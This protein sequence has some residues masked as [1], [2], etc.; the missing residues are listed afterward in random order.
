[1]SYPA[2]AYYPGPMESH[3][4]LGTENTLF[5]MDSV[6]ATLAGSTPPKDANAGGSSIHPVVDQSS[7]VDIE[8]CDHPLKFFTSMEPGVQL[9]DSN[10]LPVS[11]HLM[12][13][14]DGHRW[15]LAN[16]SS[17]IEG[18]TR[19]VDGNLICYRRNLVIVK[20][21]YQFSSGVRFLHDERRGALVPVSHLE[22][23]LS[24]QVTLRGDRMETFEIQLEVIPLKSSDSAPVNTDEDSKL[25]PLR[26][27]FGLGGGMGTYSWTRLKFPKRQGNN[28]QFNTLTV[29][30]VAVS[31]TG[32][33][34]LI[35]SS[36]SNNITVRGRSPK[37]F[38]QGI[39]LQTEPRGRSTG[40]YNQY[41][42]MPEPTRLSVL[43]SNNNNNHVSTH[44]GVPSGTNFDS[45]SARNSLLTDP[46]TLN[47][48]IPPVDLS[49][50]G[51]EGTM[52][53]L[54]NW[55]SSVGSFPTITSTASSN[56]LGSGPE[57][58]LSGFPA[59]T[60]SFS[61]YGLD[62]SSSLTSLGA[63]RPRHSSGSGDDLSWSRSF[64]PG[65]ENTASSLSGRG[66]SLSPPSTNA[67]AHPIQEP[68][69][70]QLSYQ[71][72]HSRT[73]TTD[74]ASSAF[75]GWQPSV[76]SGMPDSY[77]MP[78]QPVHGYMTGYEMEPYSNQIP[79]TSGPSSMSFPAGMLPNQLSFDGNL[80]APV[81]GTGN[82][83]DMQN[84][85]QDPMNA[86]NS[87]NYHHTYGF[88]VSSDM[89]F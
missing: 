9:L 6:P 60:H 14:V 55:F 28:H 32:A 52:S 26:I 64:T 24:A 13:R 5:V 47:S 18:I 10:R 27:P 30:L 88:G 23:V 77:M 75:Q 12:S 59:P 86:V 46:S 17:Q 29:S 80:H 87:G 66:S 54:S 45:V 38:E 76:A 2:N 40:G 31:E 62:N 41:S 89:Q 50:G 58:I 25:H 51:L 39:I 19:Q 4:S 71:Y 21:H 69:L 34:S 36:R 20:G 56:L 84:L 16:T 3:T 74:G 37:N 78:V 8:D 81:G 33:R 53:G 48:L 43:G 79:T 22:L 44:P 61:N 68:H 11:M 15:E 49:R 1:M 35:A 57:S 67:L 42:A 73:Q 7:I 70:S 82:G 72:D 85:G 83:L 65:S 63:S